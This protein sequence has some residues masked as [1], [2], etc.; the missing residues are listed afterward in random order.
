[1]TDR[2]VSFRILPFTRALKAQEKAKKDEK[3]DGDDDEEDPT[4]KQKDQQ[5]GFKIKTGDYQVST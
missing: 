3:K 4:A 5:K 1:M 2:P